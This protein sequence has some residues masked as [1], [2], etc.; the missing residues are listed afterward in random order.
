MRPSFALV[1]VLLTLSGR[2]DA[3]DALADA[4]RL[5]NQAQYEPAERAAREAMRTS[6]DPAR[7][8]LGRIRLEL[9]RQSANPEDLGEARLALRTVDPRALQGSE[10]VELTIGL[11]EALYLEDRFGAAAELFEGAIDESATLGPAAHERVLDWWASALDRLA[12]TRA[13]PERPQIYDRIV[14]RMSDEI[15]HDPG[16]TPAGYWLAAAARGCGNVERAWSAATAGWVRATLARDRGAAL[17]ADLDRLVV[18]AI[19]PERA[20]RLG[21]R[22]RSQA[23]TGM[24]SEWESFKASWAR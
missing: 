7:V 21:T 20:N 24:L 19:I 17:R 6:P 10:R 1:A 13:T 3:A 11:A 8:I 9:Y 23:I 2:V 14:R 5:Y 4:R 22:D 18:Q 12:Q 15:A 16:S